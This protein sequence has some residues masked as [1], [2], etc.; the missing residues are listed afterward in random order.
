[1]TCSA[2]AWRAT[3]DVRSV[4]P[5]ST[6][7]VVVSRPQAVAGISLITSPRHSSSLSA[8]MTMATGG[9]FVTRVILG[10]CPVIALACIA[11]AAVSLLIFNQ[12]TYDPTAWLIWGREIADWSL[13]TVAGPS[14]KPLPVIF[15]TPFS[16]LSDQAAIDLWLVL[17]RAGGIASLILAY[18]VA[19]RFY[20]HI[21]GAVATLSL[22]LANEFV[23]NW[24]RGNSE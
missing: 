1:M 4:L 12:P 2:P 5:S 20:G 19:H 11:L 7:I 13:D 23:F 6:M 10:S 24:G 9:S 17:A 18:R 14:W 3:S 15:T 21:A 8:A 22:L 16:L